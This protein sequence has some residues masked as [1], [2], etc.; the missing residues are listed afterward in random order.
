[1]PNATPFLHS[2]IF[3]PDTEP[4]Q[5][6]EIFKGFLSK[7]DLAV[8][9][10]REKHRKTNVVQQLAVCAAIGRPF[11]GFPF[12]AAKPL[13][14]VYTD[15]ESKSHSLWGRYQAICE[16]MKLT[17]IEKQRM[18]DNLR[19]IEVRKM[20]KA[21]EM[22]YRLPIKDKVDKDA[23]AFWTQFVDEY[24]NQFGADLFIFDPLRCLHSQDENDS[25]IEA[26]LSRL[27]QFFNK[28]G[29]IIPHHMT[30]RSYSPDPVTLKK[31]MR[32][33][34]DGARGS[35]AIK[36]HSDA[37]ICQE[38][39]MEDSVEIVY[40]GAFMKDGADIEPLPLEE[41]DPQSFFWQVSTEVPA[42]LRQ[43]YDTLK[44]AGGK[45]ANKKTAAEILMNAGSTKPTAYRHLKELEH[46]SLLTSKGDEL[47]LQTGAIPP[48]DDSIDIG[49]L[50]NQRPPRRKA[51]AAKN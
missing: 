5:E 49:D 23:D 28:A 47:E 42:H 27:R 30:K 8:W 17:P 25:N 21:G 38:R 10:G 18:K 24:V 45:F 44:K 51:S 32:L 29:I 19:I 50:S 39:V 35:G 22:F 16:T 15:Y 46:R 37:I 31:D 12:V 20:Q 9:I 7:G 41:S 4:A 48:T 13:K 14:V 6:E 34:S 43:A 2:Y 3:D 1:M 36:A 26:L 33:W 11:L 40:W